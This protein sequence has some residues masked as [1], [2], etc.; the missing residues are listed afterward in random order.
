MNVERQW[1]R[2]RAC[3]QCGVEIGNVHPGTCFAAFQVE[4]LNAH[5]EILDAL[6]RVTVATE[7]ERVF[8]AHAREV[9]GEMD[10]AVAESKRRACMHEVARLVTPAQ[11]SSRRTVVVLAA[12][13]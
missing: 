3:P 10:L 11:S 1:W 9:R 7:I 5:P 4:L 8:R 12:A 2:G 6:D 13:G